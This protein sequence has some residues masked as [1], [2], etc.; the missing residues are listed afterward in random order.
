MILTAK[1]ISA[2]KECAPLLRKLIDALI[3]NTPISDAAYARYNNDGA[4]VCL[5]ANPDYFFK[6]V[7]QYPE[8]LIPKNV[9]G[10]KEGFFFSGSTLPSEICELSNSFKLHNIFKFVKNHKDYTE[11]FAFSFPDTEFKFVDYYFNNLQEI[12]DIIEIFSKEIEPFLD[13]SDLIIQLPDSVIHKKI[14]TNLVPCEYELTNINFDAKGNQIRKI[15]SKQELT[16]FKLL[17]CG[18]THGQMSTI[19][20]ISSSSVATYVERVKN[21]LNCNSRAELIEYAINNDIV[22]ID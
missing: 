2:Y 7:E 6:Y 3:Q 14:S 1:N 4:Y 18:K 22:K 5:N 11:I 8:Y 16:C 17:L 15:L 21:K 13:K 10:N 19:M 12:K 20:A 9:T